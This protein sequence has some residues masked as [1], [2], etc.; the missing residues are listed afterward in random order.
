MAD[1]PHYIEITEPDW[2]IVCCDLPLGHTPKGKHVGWI[3][4]KEHGPRPKG[5]KAKRRTTVR[6]EWK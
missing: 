4:A 1:C 5:G 2:F 6:L 3:E